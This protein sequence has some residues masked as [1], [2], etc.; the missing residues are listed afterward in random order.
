MS[1]N[2]KEDPNQKSREIK[3]TAFFVENLIRLESERQK[4]TG[5]QPGRLVDYVGQVDPVAALDSRSV[6]RVKLPPRGFATL[7]RSKT[8]V[9]KKW[10]CY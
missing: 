4:K 8:L 5:A 7:I 1:L 10:N 6:L 3:G 9:E 2:W